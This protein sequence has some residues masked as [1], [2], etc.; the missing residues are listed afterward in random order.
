MGFRQ[1]Y[2]KYR[3]NKRKQY[4]QGPLWLSD[5]N[6]NNYLIYFT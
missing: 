3:N 4:G 5:S 6:N 2:Y 1:I